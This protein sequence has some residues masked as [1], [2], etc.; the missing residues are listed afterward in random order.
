[1][2]PVSKNNIYLQRKTEYTHYYFFIYSMTPSKAFSLKVVA[3]ITLII[4]FAVLIVAAIA[5]LIIFGR[6][7]LNE[8]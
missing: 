2:I 6:K 4:I 5:S 7:T 8:E 1:M 3:A